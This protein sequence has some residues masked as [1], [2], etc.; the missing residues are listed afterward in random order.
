MQGKRTPHDLGIGVALELA[1]DEVKGE[2][3]QLLN[4]HQCNLLLLALLLPLIVQVIV[5]LAM[6]HST[7]IW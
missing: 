4:A 6:S 1:V 5:H 3:C 2:G 7:K